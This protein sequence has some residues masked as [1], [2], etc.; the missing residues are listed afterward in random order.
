MKKMI[1]EN[2]P[3]D[4]ITFLEVIEHMQFPREEIE[5]ASRCLAQK[6]KI[7]LVTPNIKNFS[8]RCLGS[9]W[10][11]LRQMHIQYFSS[12]SSDAL[13][14]Q[15]GFRLVWSGC[16]FKTFPLFYYMSNLF[17][18]QIK[19]PRLF[20]INLR[21]SLGDMARLYVRNEQV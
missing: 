2:S 7:L 20:D 21:M 18:F 8:A 10:W 1:P 13:M 5:L 15:A 4:L 19:I 3:F 12:R 17:P 16:F 9:R 11:S 6:G 14:K